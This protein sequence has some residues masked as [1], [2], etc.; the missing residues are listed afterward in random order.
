MN[1]STQERDIIKEVLDLA[2]RKTTHML[3][4]VMENP[5]AKYNDQQQLDQEINV[6]FRNFP[7][8]IGHVSDS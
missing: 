5:V 6:L 8:I 1:I 3:P 2:E 7:I 4:E